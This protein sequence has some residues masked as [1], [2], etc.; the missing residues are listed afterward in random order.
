MAARVDVRELTS[1]IRAV[2]QADQLGMSMAT[3]LRAQAS[4]VRIRRQLAAEEHAMKMPIKMVFPMV[5]CLLPA[6]FIVIVGPFFLSGFGRD[7]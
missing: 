1:F 4:D 7:F 3:M 2:V 5:F 6:M